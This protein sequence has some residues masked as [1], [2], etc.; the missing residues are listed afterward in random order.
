[1]LYISNL[2]KSHD[3]LCVYSFM[4]FCSNELNSNTSSIHERIKQFLQVLTQKNNPFM[5][6]T[7]NN[8]HDRVILTTFM[9]LL[10]NC[11]VNISLYG[12]NGS[13]ILQKIIFYDS[14]KKESQMIMNKNKK[15]RKMTEDIKGLV[16]PKMKI[17]SLITPPHVVPHQ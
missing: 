17:L 13:D 4:I 2:L 1:M 8:S 9:M 7:L 16:H 14:Q 11:E 5:N 6:Q 3:G 10:Y 15:K 12:K